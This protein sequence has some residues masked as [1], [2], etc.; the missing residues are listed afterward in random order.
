MVKKRFVA[1]NKAIELIKRND[2]VK[3]KLPD[4]NKLNLIVQNSKKQRERPVFLDETYI[5]TNSESHDREE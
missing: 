3:V 1:A 2:K 4:L 5:R